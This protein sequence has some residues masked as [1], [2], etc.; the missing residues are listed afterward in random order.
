[1]PYVECRINLGCFVLLT[2][3]HLLQMAPSNEHQALLQLDVRT[4]MLYRD[5]AKIERRLN[6]GTVK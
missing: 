2:L 6:L 4:L 1:M 3:L 5:R